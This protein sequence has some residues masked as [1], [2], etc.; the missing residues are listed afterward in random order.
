M[1]CFAKNEAE[2]ISAE[3]LEEFRRLGRLF[4]A[5]DEGK[6]DDAIETGR[7]VEFST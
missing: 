6:I 7:V 2:S 4:M 3:M 1:H 5:L